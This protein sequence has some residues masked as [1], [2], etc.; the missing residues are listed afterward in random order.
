MHWFSQQV[1][2]L[3]LLWSFE[4]PGLLSEKQCGFWKHYS[5]LDLLVHFE[6]I[7]RNAFVN[8]E[9]TVECEACHPGRP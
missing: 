1:S 2:S 4:S 7:V 8:K 3:L 5:V 9:L 6:M